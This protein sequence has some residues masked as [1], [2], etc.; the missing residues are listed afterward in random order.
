MFTMIGMHNAPHCIGAQPIVDRNLLYLGAVPRASDRPMNSRGICF[1]A[2]D[3][4]FFFRHFQPAIDAAGNCGL[5]IHALLPADDGSSGQPINIVRSP[6]NRKS[7]SP[8]ALAY[9]AVWLLR[10][11]WQLQPQIVVVYSL[12]PC[13][14]MALTFLFSRVPKVVFCVTGLGI[15]TVVDDRKTRLMRHA[16]Y[17]LLRAVARS[18][19]AHFIFENN[20]DAETIGLAADTVPRW[21]T[22][23]GAGVDLSEFVQGDIPDHSTFRFAFVGRLVWSKGA[24]LAARAVSE[25]AQQGYRVSLDIYGKPDEL[26]PLPA[27]AGELSGLSGVSYRGF[28][29]DVA[30][31]WR[32]YH[33]GIFPSRGGEGLPRALLEAAA[34]GRPSIVSDVPGCR[35]FVR[36]G[37]DGYVVESAS[38]EAVKRAIIRLIAD[39]AGIAALGANAHDR[40]RQ[41]STSAAIRRK[42]EALFSDRGSDADGDPTSGTAGPR[43]TAATFAP[44]PLRGRHHPVKARGGLKRKPTAY[45]RLPR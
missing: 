38:V 14:V 40:V 39:P 25:L 7:N 2:N 34:C 9:Q 11:L 29:S 27:D 3:F 37:I 19:R 22:L 1:I 23:M 12:R 15:M 17:A 5:R 44:P 36:D 41:T 26:N 31:V 16:T 30:S 8:A 20:S 28:V 4:E 24:D 13:L 32:H 33:A 21:T 42:Y 43:E 10:K 35:D 45:S 6:I 18:R